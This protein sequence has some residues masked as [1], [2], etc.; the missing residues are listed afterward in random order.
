MRLRKTD[1]IGIYDFSLSLFCLF[2]CFFVSTT[3]E[4]IR[5]ACLLSWYCGLYVINGMEIPCILKGV[6]LP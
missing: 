1:A 2:V 5:V 6:M 3:L 4:T